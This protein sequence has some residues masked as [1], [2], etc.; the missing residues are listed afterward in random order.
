[1]LRRA[2][3]LPDHSSS[4]TDAVVAA[5]RAAD[6]RRLIVAMCDERLRFLQ[7]LK[8]WPVFGTGWGRRVAEVKSMALA[9]VANAPAPAP[10]QAAAPGQAMGPIANGI[11]H[12]ST[13]AIAG[14]GAAAT[15]QAHQS[16]MPP[17]ALASIVAATVALATAAW[18]FWHWRQRWKQEAPAMMA[19][20]HRKS[21]EH[22]IGGVQSMW[23]K[24]KTWFKNSATILWA[25]IVALAGLL[26]AVG[27]SLLTDPN[28]SSA[29]QAALQPKY[30]PYY[31][32][33]IGLVTEV[34][35]RR[36]AGKVE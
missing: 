11:R 9:M 24:I 4:V 13:G 1:V 32:I 33:A 10:P 31:V 7:S 8:T 5:A 26:L 35:R 2:L 12:G 34:A 19:G 16:G 21:K 23:D 30:I 15:Q 18:L 29:I 3:K 6:A 25:R 27:Q 28:V 20:T 14:A 36:T 22:L 17:A